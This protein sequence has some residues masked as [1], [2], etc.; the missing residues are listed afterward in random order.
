M[1]TGLFKNIVNK[2]KGNMPPPKHRYPKNASPV[3]HNTTVTQENDIKYN[4]IKMI[5]VIKEKINRSL[6]EIEEHIIKWIELF[7]DKTNKLLKIYTTK[8]VQKLI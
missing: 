2:S 4:I 3:Y 5:E 1:T 7:K 8:Q 6:K